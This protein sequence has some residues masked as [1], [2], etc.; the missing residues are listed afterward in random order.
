M[1]NEMR[2]HAVSMNYAMA[3]SKSWRARTETT[4]R[5]PYKSMSMMGILGD[6]PSFE[7]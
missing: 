4:H 2:I 3:T 5:E 1:D 6:R 7:F